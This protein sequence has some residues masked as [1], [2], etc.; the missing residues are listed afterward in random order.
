MNKDIYVIIEQLDGIIK[1][2]SLELIGEANRLSKKLGEKVIAV[3][4]GNDIED[5]AELLIK[6]GA[7][8]VLVIDD[9]MLEPYMTS[10]YTKA[11][12]SIIEKRKP[13]IVLFP[14]TSIGRDLAPRVAAR[15]G[16]GLSADVTDFDID[17]D[18]KSLL[19]MMPAFGGNIMA[20][21]VSKVKRP[22]MATVRA[23]VMLPLEKDMN[24]S[25]KIERFEIEF[26]DSDRDVLIREVVI[27]AEEKDDISNAEIIVAGGIG[28]GAAHH[29]DELKVLADEL[30]GKLGATRPTVDAGWIDKSR[31]IGQTGKT[32][33]PELFIG[34]GISGA[35]QLVSGMKKSKYV[36]AVNKDP[37]AL[38]FDISDFGI[39]G[40]ANK[41]I[42]LLI[43]KI[44]SYKASKIHK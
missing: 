13:S 17:K 30:N 27:E 38:I 26:D 12:S 21:I 40:D 34:F 19:M 9:P 5:K 20:T 25:G 28:M 35:I 32:V 41:I 42:P 43:K 2:V 16:T 7:D 18:D 1:R 39:V 33:R 3:L 22:E 31:Q 23:G 44:Q 8:E 14:A 15:I 36:I 10:P 29:F 24:R 11:V 37:K 6:Y 4:L